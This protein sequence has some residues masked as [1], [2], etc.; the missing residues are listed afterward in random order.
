M[1]TLQILPIMKS[2]YMLYME[3]KKSDLP[4][5]FRQIEQTIQHSDDLSYE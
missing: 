1:I 3:E 4:L 5:F 2:S